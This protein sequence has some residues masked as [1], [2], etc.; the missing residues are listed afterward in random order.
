MGCVA[1]FIRFPACKNFDNQLR[2]GKITES[3]KLG[4]FLSQCILPV[5]II[6]LGAL[7]RPSLM[8]CY[9]IVDPSIQLAKSIFVA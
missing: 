7:C 4:I 6:K 2:F 5:L 8:N 3:L 9:R 1:N